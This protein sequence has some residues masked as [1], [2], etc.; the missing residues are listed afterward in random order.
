[1]R[2]LPYKVKVEEICQ[3]FKSFNVAEKAVVLG[4][5]PDGRKN[6]FGAVLLKSADEA[7]AVVRDLDKKYIG[8]R[9]LTLSTISHKDFV[10]FN[11]PQG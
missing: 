11:T 10:D 2:G 6:G 3:F 9:Y 8:D 4:A 1:M 7:A 5:G